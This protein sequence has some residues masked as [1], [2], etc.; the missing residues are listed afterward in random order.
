M[1]YNRQVCVILF[2]MLMCFTCCLLGF[3]FMHN[4]S[5]I[6]PLPIINVYI[7]DTLTYLQIRCN[8][9]MHTNLVEETIW[10]LC[11]GSSITQAPKCS[12]QVYGDMIL[13]SPC[14]ALLKAFP[15]R[16]S[17]NVNLVA[18]SSGI[19]LTCALIFFIIG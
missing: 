8:S 11:I 13:S 5:I 15:V 7:S 14:H 6:Y 18:L 2:C 3:V 19:S 1:N 17:L 12:S 16:V 9:F 10:P 4:P